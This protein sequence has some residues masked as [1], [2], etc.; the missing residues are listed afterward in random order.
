MTSSKFHS[1][2]PQGSTESKGEFNIEI[3]GGNDH[4][5]A[6]AALVVFAMRS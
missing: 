3:E 2:F 1:S 6:M 4:L 5:L